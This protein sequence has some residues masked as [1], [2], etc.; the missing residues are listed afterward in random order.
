[1]KIITE[2]IETFLGFLNKWQALLWMRR[3]TYHEDA[4]SP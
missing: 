3:E 4:N 1:M 2:H